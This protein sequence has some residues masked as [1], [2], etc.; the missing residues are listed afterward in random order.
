MN[1]KRGRT[2]KVAHAPEQDEVAQFANAPA[3]PAAEKAPAKGK[4]K[5]TAVEERERTQKADNKK[6]MVDKSVDETNLR[7]SSRIKDIKKK[8]EDKQ[9]APAAQDPAPAAQ[10]IAPVVP[11]VPVAPPVVPVV[12][13]VPVSIE[14][15]TFLP[16]DASPRN[17]ITNDTH[18]TLIRTHDFI[19]APTYPLAIHK[20]ARLAGTEDMGQLAEAP[21]VGPRPMSYQL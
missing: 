21:V 20:A 8:N 3:K 6:K 12:P 9:P 10:P 4:K 18:V 1:R 14:E 13:I 11:I 2:A 19:P 15:T 7:R 17:L 16:I 5:V